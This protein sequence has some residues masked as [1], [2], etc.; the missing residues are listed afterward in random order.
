MPAA[1]QSAN[2]KNPVIQVENVS[3][4]YVL[5]TL[6]GSDTLYEL[7]AGLLSP[8]RRAKE[9][10][11]KVTKFLALNNISFDIEAGEVV[12]VIGRNGAGKSTLL[13]IL[14]RITAPT[15]GRILLRGRLASLLE[16]GTGFHPELS[17]RENIFLNGSILGMTRREVESKYDEIVA[18]AEVEKFIHT[19]V[20]RYS[21]G[22]YVRLAFA[23]AAHLEPDVLI[24]DEVL[25]VGDAAF[26]AKCLGKISS[27]AQGGRTV[28]FVSH[29][30]QAVQ[31]LCT[32]C[33]LLD[34][35]RV[36]AAG[37]PERVIATY[38]DSTNVQTT[39]SWHDST[40]LGNDKLRL[41]SISLRASGG[42]AASSVMSSNDDIEVTLEIAVARPLS[43]LCVG[44][45]LLGSQGN[46]I[47]RS[48]NTDMSNENIHAI[49]AGRSQV[50]C[51][52]PRGLLN[53]GSYTLAPR[54]SIH[55]QEWI[56]HSD[57]LTG[58]AIVLNHGQ[59]P[60][61]NSLDEKSRPGVIAPILE[62]SVVHA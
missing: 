50:K 14:S 22:M 49:P 5:G 47:L 44:F 24:I 17:G 8:K 13:K 4:E 45:D 1:I 56:V 10:A 42:N 27:V 2:V 23:V 58:F 53:A 33:I 16:V 51:I 61:W 20:K 55:N 26:Q 62:W 32:R 7:A 19:P 37:S 35:G 11:S 59:S 48:Y 57:A 36:A 3:K 60:Y 6:R 28:L 40:G 12:G 15:Q 38:L 30:M 29:N 31:S 25:A 9:Q 54:I 46:T 39:T 43:G 41:H 52:L 21:S 34:E 18:F